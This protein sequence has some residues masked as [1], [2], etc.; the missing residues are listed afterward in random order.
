MKLLHRLTAITW[1]S[2]GAAGVKLA[3]SWHTSPCQAA[4]TSWFPAKRGIS[5]NEPFLWTLPDGSRS[6]AAGC[7][8]NSQ[9]SDAENNV[10]SC[11][12]I[13]KVLTYEADDAA[14]E[15][16]QVTAVSCH[17]GFLLRQEG[18]SGRLHHVHGDLSDKD[19][20]ERAQKEEGY[21]MR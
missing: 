16:V 18:F 21:I 7:K 14:D 13:W 17:D 10:L 19:L 11:C 8:P 2:S 1:G 15:G 6:T 20:R 9:Y 4:L 3:F 5:M 12:L